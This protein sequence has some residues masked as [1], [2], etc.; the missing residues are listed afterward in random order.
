LRGYSQIDAEHEFCAAV[1]ETSVSAKRLAQALVALASAEIF[2]PAPPHSSEVQVRW[3]H[4]LMMRGF[5][6]DHATA[7]IPDVPVRHGP[8][9]G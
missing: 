3:G 4:L 5:S 8:D 9:N 2:E 1:Q 7:S 6:D